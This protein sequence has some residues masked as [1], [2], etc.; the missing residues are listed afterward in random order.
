MFEYYGKCVDEIARKAFAEISEVESA[1]SEAEKRHKRLPENPSGRV[2]DSEYIANAARATADYANANAR[3]FAMQRDLPESV[4]QAVKPIRAE[5][6][7]AIKNKYRAKPGDID[8]N[9]LALLE[10]GI[11]TVDDYEALMNE[12]PNPTMSKM[13]AA[14]A[15]KAA[16]AATDRNEATRLRI[17]AQIGKRLDGSEALEAFDAIVETMNRTIANTAMIPY[18]ESLTTPFI[19][20]M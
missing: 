9:T 13:I 14:A 18:W 10:S 5:L 20:A 16:E 6:V 3:R 11:M 19:D 4:R 1:Y 17:L 7:E 8:Q 2:V 12:S 15:G